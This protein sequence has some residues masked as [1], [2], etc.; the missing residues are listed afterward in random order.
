[1]YNSRH[2][3]T[4]AST[5][6]HQCALRALN[7]SHHLPC[8][9]ATPL[10]TRPVRATRTLSVPCT[11]PTPPALH[12]IPSTP[13]LMCLGVTRHICTLPTRPLGALR[14]SLTPGCTLSPRP[15]P[16]HTWHT[17][18]LRTSH[19]TGPMHH[20]RA[21]RA[22]Y[23]PHVL[24]NL[25][26]PSTLG[27]GHALRAVHVPYTPCAGST[28]PPH[29]P[30]TWLPPPAMGDRRESWQVSPTLTVHRPRSRALADLAHHLSH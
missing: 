9:L 12:T 16:S 5:P 6:R 22:V 23:M 21:A 10:H 26:T 14:T 20:L 29:A 17:C 25:C 4:Q 27:T 15:S 11:P 18:W 13:Y 8:V 7:P 2:P 30:S 1:M 3:L 24:H 28:C 19:S